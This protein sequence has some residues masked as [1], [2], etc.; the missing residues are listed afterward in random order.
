MDWKTYIQ[1]LSKSLRIA[2]KHDGMNLAERYR[3]YGALEAAL[4]AVGAFAGPG[5]AFQYRQIDVVDDY[6][7]FKHRHRRRENYGEMIERA[8]RE[9]LEQQE[10]RGSKKYVVEG[11]ET[12]RE[13]I[14]ADDPEQAVM[15]FRAKYPACQPPVCVSL[16]DFGKDGR[17]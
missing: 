8:A 3:A 2:R 1:N 11:T 17:K 15:I 9:W 5:K 16:E 12:V 4:L 14:G 13:V 10:I 7:F 6:I